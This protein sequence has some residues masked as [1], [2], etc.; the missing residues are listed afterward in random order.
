MF[1]GKLKSYKYI[2]ERLYTDFGFDYNFQGAEAIEWLDSA[3]RDLGLNRYYV[4][5]VTDGNLD[6]GHQE[7]IEISNYTGALPCDLLGIVQSAVLL[8]GDYRNQQCSPVYLGGLVYYDYNNRKVCVTGQGPES[9]DCQT[10]L[11]WPSCA[12]DNVHAPTLNCNQK[13]Y[14]M[15]PMR[16]NTSTMYKAHGPYNGTHCTNL[17]FNTHSTYTYQVNNNRITTNFKE[18]KVV[19]AYRAIPTDENG[20]PMIPDDNA[21]IEFIL[22]SIASRIAQKLYLTDKWTADKLALMVNTRDT[23][24]LKAISKTQ[25]DNM[26][27]YE[28]FK[29]ARLR[30]F[31]TPLDHRQFFAN[32]NYNQQI[33]QQPT[34]RELRPYN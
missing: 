15:I 14:V 7:P 18:G 17:D 5:K 13:S 24:Y 10:L 23:M 12:C 34:I 27:Y 2:L 1:N 33:Y 3:L 19:M 32:L 8:E 22:Y 26:D 30:V 25:L 28:S 29:N 11:D 9:C 16:Y 6:A 4:D 20:Y 31:K 21:A